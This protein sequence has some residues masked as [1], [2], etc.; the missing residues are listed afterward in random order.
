MDKPTVLL[1]M[2]GGTDS[3]VAAML[4]LEAG[5]RLTGVTFRF[6]EP[7]D[8]TAYLDQARALA[9]RLGFPHFVY[10][11]RALF[12]REVMDYFVDEYRRGRTPVPCTRCNT[13]LKWPLL[14]RLADERGIARLATG[15][16]ARLAHCEGRTRLLTAT[17]PDKDQSCF[18][19]GLPEAML[20]RLLLPLGTL[21]Q[22]EV[23][24]IATE[25]GF[26]EVAGRKGSVGVCFC[27]QGYRSFLRHELPADALRPGWFVDSEGRRLG[28]HEGIPFYT[29]GQR[30]GLGLQM[31]RPVFVSR[32]CPAD[33]TIHLADY[34][35][36]RC[37]H[38]WLEQWHLFDASLPA[39]DREVD[40]KI[41][42][43]LQTDRC[44][45]SQE[46][47]LLH[48]QLTTPLYAA[49][50]GQAAVLYEADRLLGGGIIRSVG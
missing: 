49:A 17:D 15:H 46:G 47:V 28:R 50:P 31:N 34:A 20:S 18:L 27:P 13:R 7:D 36:L 19:W 29:V 40:L 37:H 22:A 38:L 3:S 12:R 42:Y 26:P 4:L 23:R 5:Y 33:A 16:Y 25:R 1:G 21:T 44:R 6:F 10:D 24:R 30:H 14:A 11:A 43:R 39:P 45:V 35:S 48:L 9:D 32:L 8:S 41:R 2:S